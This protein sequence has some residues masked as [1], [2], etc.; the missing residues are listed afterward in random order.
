MSRYLGHDL[1]FLIS[2]P[3]SGSTLMQRVLAGHPDIQTSAETWMM[4]HPVY[5]QRQQGIETE[6]NARWRQEAMAEF[7]ANY[8]DGPEVHDDA[9]RAYA[10]VLYGNALARGGKR[11][12]LDKTPRYFFIIEDLYRLFP[13]A[14]FIFLL[15]NPL[16]V[17]ASELSTYVKGDWK[18]IGWF[19]P[20]LIDAP[21]LIDKG[22]RQV[23]ARGFVIRYEDFVE[24][25]ETHT[26]RLC[27][28]LG[29]EMQGTM[30]DYSGTPAPIG[31]MNDPVGV[32]RHSRPTP[33]SAESWKKLAE[34]V[35]YRH[36]AHS[37]LD[38]IGPETLTHLGYDEA[39]LRAAMG[40]PPDPSTPGIYPWAL[41]IKPKEHW[42]LV[43]RL[44]HES[45]QA[46]LRYPG[47]GI[48]AW[49]GAR[50]RLLQYVLRE[51]SFALGR[52]VDRY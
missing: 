17:L 50:R 37:L 7:I 41:S 21:S 6:Y 11:F 38:A 39:G 29:I 31:A 51:L 20:D 1:I 19:A 49:L 30:V 22:I 42:L 15:R 34:T 36:F 2:Q 33:D 27:D 14:R 32:H 35:Q 45:Y 16:A 43:E 44:R 10:R 25:P 5:G 24:D 12:F 52:G 13:E 3:R 18:I 9:I 28:Y 4:L 40:D 8:T 46:T 47:N 26:A 48:A 23:G